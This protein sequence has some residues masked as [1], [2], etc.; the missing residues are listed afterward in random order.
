MQWKLKYFS[1]QKR[2]SL[3]PPAALVREQNDPNSC[4]PLNVTDLFARAS[5][6]ERHTHT[7]TVLDNKRDA[8]PVRQA[9]LGEALCNNDIIIIT[10]QLYLLFKK[11]AISVF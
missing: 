11:I 9:G 8:A 2:D 3:P 4:M 6:E 7:L 1:I 10:K 5:T